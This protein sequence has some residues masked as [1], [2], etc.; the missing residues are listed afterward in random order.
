MSVVLLASCTS[1]PGAVALKEAAISEGYDVTVETV[2]R[3]DERTRK[4]AQLGI[5]LPVLVRDDGAMSDDGKNWVRQK[6]AR[7]KTT[8]PLPDEEVIVDASDDHII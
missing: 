8:N 4:S 2:K 3:S 7:K 6:K 5:G 1:C